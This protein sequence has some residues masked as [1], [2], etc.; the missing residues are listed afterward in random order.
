MLRSRPRSSD[1]DSSDFAVPNEHT[2]RQQLALFSSLI[3]V[4]QLVGCFFK[5]K[6]AP[7]TN[8]SSTSA[9]TSDTT[10]MQTGELPPTSS[11]ST[12]T[13]DSPTTSG[14]TSPT[15][16]TGSSPSTTIAESSTGSTPECG[17]GVI[18]GGEECD[19]GNIDDTD[20][21]VKGCHVAECGDGYVRADTEACDDMNASNADG[22]VKC[23]LAYCGDGAKWDGVEFCD[24]GNLK[25]DDG[26]SN[27]CTLPRYVFITSETYDGTLAPTIDNKSGI[28]LADAHCQALA[29]SAQL[30]GYFRA[31]ISVGSNDPVDRFD[32]S[33]KGAYRLVDGTSIASNGWQSFANFEHSNPIAKDEKND[34]AYGQGVWTST[35]STGVGANNDCK[36]WSSIAMADT[37]LLGLSS[38]GM[39]NVNP[40][41]AW[42]DY[43]AF[44]CDEPHRLY[45]IQDLP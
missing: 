44:G 20:N 2:L 35:L 37:A 8:S 7:D 33:F 1:I 13:P 16:T 41:Q 11:D 19:D 29:A 43:A 36:G 17:N 32:T 18:E 26:C 12:S 45:C 22:C 34:V 31:W 27:Y 30:S 5:Q 40:P 10:A 28:E 6:E 3:L 23:K 15:A 25:N 9:Q 42:T 14:S 24:D 4:P 38:S 39:N 21:C